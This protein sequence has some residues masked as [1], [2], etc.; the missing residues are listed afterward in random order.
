MF[1]DKAEIYIKAGN[2][3]NGCVSFHREKYVAAGG[4]DGGDGGRGGSVYLQAD[5][6]LST[7]MDFRY[8]KKYI[9]ENGTDGRG[10]RCAGKDG[11][12]LTVFVPVGTIVKDNLT[13]LI[14]ADMTEDGERFC[15]CKGGNGGW[16]NTHFATPTRQVP[17]FAKSG[18]KGSEKNITL[19]LKLLA[20]VG[21]L[22]FPNVGKS[23]FLS[24]VSDAQPKIANYHFTT[25]IPNLGVVPGENGTSFVIADIPGIIEG[26]SEGIGLGHEF[27]RHV[28][29]TRLLIH[30]VDVSGIEGRDPYEDF[31]TINNELQKF[32]PQLADKE[33][34]VAPNKIDLLYDK[35]VLA[36]FQKKMEAEGY[37]V[38][39]ISGATREGVDELIN[40]VRERLSQIEVPVLYDTDRADVVIQYQPDEEKPFQIIKDGG[41]YEVTGSFIERI[42]GS[43][44]FEDSESTQYFQR[45]LRRKGVI[46]AL[47]EAGCQEGDTVRMLDFEFDFI[48]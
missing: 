23:T 43:T 5:K 46:E 25:L 38:F 29:R 20:D 1:V 45:A 8:K 44:N 19:E 7:L 3:G 21:L 12:D 30:V 10:A 48:E 34:I 4:P 47:K 40:F 9:A 32:N 13:D 28:E 26:A 24:M 42:M 18:L 33:Q 41:V 6:K 14:I 37:R 17:R 2:G 27:L 15:I 16:G 39:P 22:G 31:V 11:N 35:S 36:E